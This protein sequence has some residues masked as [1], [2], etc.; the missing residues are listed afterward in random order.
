MTTTTYVASALTR[1]STRLQHG[2]GALRLILVPWT[3]LRG[4]RRVR[5]EQLGQLR[6]TPIR[7]AM[8]MSPADITATRATSQLANPSPRSRVQSQE[9]PNSAQPEP[10]GPARQLRIALEDV[11]NR[12]RVHVALRDHRAWDRGQG[13]QKQ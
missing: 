9:A 3:G 13:Q 1:T 12:E 2:L 7:L 4:T 8:T 6:D 10:I 11:E 5:R